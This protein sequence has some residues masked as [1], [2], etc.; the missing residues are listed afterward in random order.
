[1]IGS[2]F[3]HATKEGKRVHKPF[4]SQFNMPNRNPNSAVSFLFLAPRYHTNMVGWVKAL[5]GA[6]N[7]VR[8]AVVNI[9]L[10]EDHGLLAPITLSPTKRAAR[11]IEKA[12]IANVTDP[13]EDLRLRYF[14]PRI[15]PLARIIRESS[16]DVLFL[17]REMRIAGRVFLAVLLSGRKLICVEYDQ[18]PLDSGRGRKAMLRGFILHILFQGRYRMTSSVLSR[19][20][21]TSAQ[22]ECLLNTHRQ[23]FLPFSIEC[24]Q[25]TSQ[26]R[27]RVPIQILA[28][29][30][31]RPYKSWDLLVDSLLRMDPALREKLK[32]TIIGQAKLEIELA[33][34]KYLSSRIEEAALQPIIE[35]WPNVKPTE[36]RTHY[37]RATCTLLVSRNESA[38]I[39]PLEGM[40]FGAF[41]ITTSE[42]GTNCYFEKS[43]SGLVFESGNPEE[44]AK[45][46][47]NLTASSWKL[48]EMRRATSEV[49]KSRV[50]PE[51][52]L[53]QVEKVCLGASHA[54]PSKRDV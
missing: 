41:P 17:R 13:P 23:S 7:S 37:E 38:A 24:H 30:K 53:K 50:S 36:M 42:N 54:H 2:F 32:I 48:D 19:S 52:F 20:P 8:V 39:S 15:R 46:L 11:R 27:P 22:Y 44:L 25:T 1:M 31:M 9:G 47:E 29:G 4:S 26:T 49:L 6:G 14:R 16:A 18:A 10:T 3:R 33:H 28:V 5:V 45:L 40:S 43:I 34:L 12:L 35:L 51:F 21:L